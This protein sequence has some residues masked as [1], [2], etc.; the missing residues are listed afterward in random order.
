MS[1]G[2]KGRFLFLFRPLALVC[3]K[4]RTRNKEFTR[5]TLNVVKPLPRAVEGVKDFYSVYAPPKSALL[6]REQRNLFVGVV[7]SLFF[8]PGRPSVQCQSRSGPVTP[9]SSSCWS[10]MRFMLRSQGNVDKSREVGQC[11]EEAQRG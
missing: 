3:Q 2:S 8:V 7:W 6:L 10:G 11:E 9:K 5:S 4:I 1:P